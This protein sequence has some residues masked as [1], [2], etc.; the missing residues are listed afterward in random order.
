MSETKLPYGKPVKL[1]VELQ[2]FPDG[3]LMLFE[4]WRKKG[5]NEE[6]VSDVY[7]V[8]KGGKASGKWIPVI[9][10]EAVLP[11]V[12]KISEQVEEEKYYFIAKL[13]DQEIKSGDMVF[14]YLLDIQ[15]ADTDGIPVNGVEYTV[16][17]SD[18]SKENGVF[19]DGHAKFEDAPLG[20]F[21]IELENYEF[22]KPPGKILKGRWDKSEIKCEDKVKMIVDVEDF[23]DGTPAKF[24]VYEYDGV[25]K[26]Y[27]LVKDGIS[28]EVKEDQVEVEWQFEYDK[29]PEDVKEFEGFEEDYTFPE[30]I[31]D[32]EIEDVSFRCY[33]RLTCY[34]GPLFVDEEEKPIKDTKALAYLPDGRV[35]PCRIL[36]GYLTE[37][38]L[39]QRG[40]ISIHLV[41][42]DIGGIE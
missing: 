21:T 7:G 19:K 34:G 1:L 16:T 12:E 13:D 20:K 28:G 4:I 18:G 35:I 6:K 23:D 10:R 26:N 5:G 33:K 40:N 38:Y 15:V 37:P 39:W 14:T 27:Y 2:G 29:N 24:T 31:F 17:F 42:D 41:Y 11:L 32:V 3:R 9:E 25:G 22:V 30:F 36:K 8:T